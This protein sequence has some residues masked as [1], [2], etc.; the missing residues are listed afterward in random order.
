MS[1]NHIFFWVRYIRMEFG[2]LFRETCIFQMS[3]RTLLRAPERPHM[4]EFLWARLASDSSISPWPKHAA[5]PWCCDFYPFGSPTDTSD[6]VLPSKASF[7]QNR[8][9]TEGNSHME[10]YSSYLDISG[11]LMYVYNGL[12]KQSTFSLLTISNR[13]IKPS[14]SWNSVI[15]CWLQS[16]WVLFTVHMLCRITYV[17]LHINY[18]QVLLNL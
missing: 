2:F 8:T 10:A 3:N 5:C 16:L 18:L 1:A 12:L 17:P 15:T 6:M 13:A 14:S 9:C 11:F 7:K 4:R